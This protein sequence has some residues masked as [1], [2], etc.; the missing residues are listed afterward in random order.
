MSLIKTVYN[1][2]LYSATSI[3]ILYFST[4]RF[5]T[6]LPAVSY[7]SIICICERSLL[8]SIF[9]ISLVGFGYR[10]AEILLLFL[11]PA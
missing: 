4:L 9:K 3:S 1:P 2:E 5:L 11:N 8:I 7:I 6:F 10:K